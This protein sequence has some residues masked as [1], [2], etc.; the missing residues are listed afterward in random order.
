MIFPIC[1]LSA[2]TSSTSSLPARWPP[3]F[4]S[5]NW[6]RYRSNPSLLVRW[7]WFALSISCVMDSRRRALPPRVNFCWWL[8]R[9][10]SC[11][12]RRRRQ[13]PPRNERRAIRY[14]LILF[15]W[16]R[17]WASIEYI[18]YEHPNKGA[19]PIAQILPY[20]LLLDN[21]E[22]TGSWPIV[23]YWKKIESFHLNYEVDSSFSFIIAV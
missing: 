6:T 14:T 1:S 8:K 23:M 5:W 18:I 12:C 2:R 20:G 7:T 13:R 9:G 21:I 11:R 17:R 4:L 15:S 19:Y 16:R 3:G 10:V 22:K